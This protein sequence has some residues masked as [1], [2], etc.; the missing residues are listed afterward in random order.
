MG[1]AIQALKQVWCWYA[2]PW[3]PGGYCLTSLSCHMQGHNGLLESPTGT[4]KTLCLL[5]AALAWQKTLKPVNTQVRNTPRTGWCLDLLPM[6]THTRAQSWRMRSQRHLV[7]HTLHLFVPLSVADAYICSA[8][9]WQHAAK[10]VK[11]P[12]MI[13]FM[14]RGAFIAACHE[15][16]RSPLRCDR[17]LLQAIKKFI[18]IAAR[19]LPA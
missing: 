1:K 13:T 15:L 16:K 8:L 17:K 11:P 9:L 6:G 4:G 2:F 7:L 5:C 10:K 3:L 14:E 12:L 18:T 19:T